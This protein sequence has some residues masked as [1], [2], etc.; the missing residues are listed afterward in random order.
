MLIAIKAQET[1]SH[2]PQN[3]SDYDGPK[4]RFSH[5]LSGSELIAFSATHSPT[6]DRGGSNSAGS[7]F[8]APAKIT[9]AKN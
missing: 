9:Y 3:K 8:A 1:L 2:A 4:R 5:I 6:V 7:Q